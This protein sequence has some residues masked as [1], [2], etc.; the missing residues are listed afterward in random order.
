M[1]FKHSNETNC[2]KILKKKIKLDFMFTDPE[3]VHVR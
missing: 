3:I 2:E 1:E